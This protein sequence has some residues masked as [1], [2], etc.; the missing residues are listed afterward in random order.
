MSQP[1]VTLRPLTRTDL[2]A[3]TPWFEDRDTRRY[4]G[5]PDWPAAILQQS[6][7]LADRLTNRGLI[8][9]IKMRSV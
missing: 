9:R 4:L 8:S 5:G 2:A 1:I 7:E 6:P 3:I